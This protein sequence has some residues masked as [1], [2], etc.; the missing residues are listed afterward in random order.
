MLGRNNYDARLLK[1]QIV[2]SLCYEVY[3]GFFRVC[4]WT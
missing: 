1:H 2:N 3:Q 4:V